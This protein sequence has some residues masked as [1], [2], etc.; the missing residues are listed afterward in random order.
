MELAS[1]TFS[2]V[3]V[4]NK[5]QSRQ[6]HN[7]PKDC[8]ARK[9]CF[10]LIIVSKVAPLASLIGSYCE[11]IV[12]DSRLRERCGAQ[13]SDSAPLSRSRAKSSNIMSS[14]CSCPFSSLREERDR[15]IINMIKRVS[16]V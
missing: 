12:C 13:A 16:F 1:L 10:W 7:S 14:S 9:V 11:R 5:C 2:F 4:S 6:F 8:I 3:L 15:H